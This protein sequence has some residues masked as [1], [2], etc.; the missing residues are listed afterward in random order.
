[1][2]LDPPARSWPPLT[3]LVSQNSWDTLRSS[4]R[5]GLCASPQTPEKGDRIFLL[6]GARCWH[7]THTPWLLHDGLLWKL[8]LFV[9]FLIKSFVEDFWQLWNWSI[10]IFCIYIHIHIKIYIFK[11]AYMD[12]H[13]HIYK[14]IHI[15]PCD[16]YTD[17]SY[18]RENSPI[19]F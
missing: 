15:I 7:V 12:I 5:L 4:R 8:G 18:F 19:L 14:Y 1:M 3:M 2:F 16:I 17:I 13:I 9:H 11:H 6:Q 10:R